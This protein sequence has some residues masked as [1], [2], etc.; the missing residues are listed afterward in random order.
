MGFVLTI[1]MGK[2]NRA[3]EY[4]EMQIR[5]AGKMKGILLL[6]EN[7]AKFLHRAIDEPELRKEYATKAFNVIVQLQMALKFEGDGVSEAL[8]ILYDYLHKLLDKGDET[9]LGEGVKLLEHLTETFRM[10]SRTVGPST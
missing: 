3:V 5:T 8:F 10:L 4:S 2:L 1:V 9:S 7:G 6:H